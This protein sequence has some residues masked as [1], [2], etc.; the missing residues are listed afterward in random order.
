[1]SPDPHYESAVNL[2]FFFFGNVYNSHRNHPHRPPLRNEWNEVKNTIMNH[3]SGT[4]VFRLIR[5]KTIARTAVRYIM[6]LKDLYEDDLLQQMIIQLPP[7][8]EHKNIQ[9]TLDLK[10]LALQQTWELNER[11]LDSFDSARNRYQLLSVHQRVGTFLSYMYELLLGN[12]SLEGMKV[13]LR[14]LVDDL[15]THRWDIG[16]GQWYAM[17]PLVLSV[18]NP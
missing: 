12:W 6:N 14:V 2:P 3:G 18:Q 5:T 17:L 7:S 8:A 15:N 16:H 1:M 4:S 11:H 10:R 9:Q 13:Q